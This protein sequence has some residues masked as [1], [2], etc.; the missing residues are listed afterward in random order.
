MTRFVPLF[1]QQSWQVTTHMGSRQAEDATIPAASPHRQPTHHNLANPIARHTL[2]LVRWQ[3]ATRSRA[4]RT[5][6]RRLH[7]TCQYR[8]L[9]IM[10]QR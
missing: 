7:H 4:V 2:A 5:L 8:T 10:S 1:I 6:R 9:R 3:E